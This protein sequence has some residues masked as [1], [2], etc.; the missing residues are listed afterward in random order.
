MHC[1][2]LEFL[3]TSIP[4]CHP[5][6]SLLSLVVFLDVMYP[7]VQESFVSCNSIICLRITNMHVVS[8][9]KIIH[10][11]TTL[12]GKIQA[13]S[14]RQLINHLYLSR[15]SQQEYKLHRC[16]LKLERIQCKPNIT[17]SKPCRMI[18]FERCSLY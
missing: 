5:T 13:K 7:I 8:T 12:M 11:H 18:S 3:S 16:H 1:T 9:I 6:S 14:C 15:W 4:Y 2:L 17:K 10:S